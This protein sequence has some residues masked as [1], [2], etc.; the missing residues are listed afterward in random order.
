MVVAIA[1]TTMAVAT[2]AVVALWWVGV[3]AVAVAAA[4]V[5]GVAMAVAVVRVRAVARAVVRVEA[6]WWQIGC[7]A[8]SCDG[9]DGG[10]CGH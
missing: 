7:C 8:G 5:V 4:M 3:V 10:G 2:E 6:R 1:R 9:K